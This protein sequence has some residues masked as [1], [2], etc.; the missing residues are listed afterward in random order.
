MPTVTTPMGMPPTNSRNEDLTNTAPVQA[1]PATA[2]LMAQ[3]E[4]DREGRQ[5]MEDRLPKVLSAKDQAEA[6]GATPER[7]GNNEP[8]ATAEVPLQ[9]VRGAALMNADPARRTG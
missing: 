7:Y 9:R 1:T 5:W 3:Q 2:A 8:T 6:T 4:K